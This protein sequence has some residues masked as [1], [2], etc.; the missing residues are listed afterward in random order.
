MATAS[1]PSQPLP[2][3]NSEQEYWNGVA[4]DGSPLT[5]VSEHLAPDV[6]EGE[7]LPPIGPH[8]ANAG[9]RQGPCPE[10][11]EG[12]RHHIKADEEVLAAER[13]HIA[14]V[15]CSVELMQSVVE[16][17]KP[18]RELLAAQAEAAL[19]EQQIANETRRRHLERLKLAPI[20]EIIEGEEDDVGAPEG[21]APAPVALAS[22]PM[23]GE[24]LRLS[25][26]RDA[27]EGRASPGRHEPEA[28]GTHGRD[29]NATRAPREPRV[30]NIKFS[31]A[32]LLTL[33]L[34]A[35]KDLPAL[36]EKLRDLEAK[37]LPAEAELKL[38]Q[39]FYLDRA[40]S[41][42][43]DTLNSMDEKFGKLGFGHWMPF[44]YIDQ[45]LMFTGILNRVLAAHGLM[46]SGNAAVYRK[47]LDD[48]DPIS[49]ACA[50]AGPPKSY[51]LGYR[52]REFRTMKDMLARIAENR[53]GRGPPL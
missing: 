47:L 21:D 26:A 36:S 19:I 30:P 35:A 29:G 34:R 44:R 20:E 12:S 23:S 9:G 42:V 43:T 37:L 13:A 15:R 6:L 14:R 41:I 27:R 4:D 39:E 32:L 33:A 31:P 53:A 49:P 11:V 25:P 17:G 24:C 52:V 16:L 45:W 2:V 10:P 48:T 40:V 5:N 50:D 8:A 28:R 38:K 51:G 18:A 3:P 1:D 46:P 7:K 22:S